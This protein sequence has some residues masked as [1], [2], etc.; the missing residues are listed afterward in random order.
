LPAREKTCW[1]FERG[2]RG[3]RRRLLLSLPPKIYADYVARSAH[4]PL[5]YSRVAK[6]TFSPGSCLGIRF[7]LLDLFDRY[8]TFFRQV[9][10]DR[11]SSLF[12]SKVHNMW[13]AVSTSNHFQNHFQVTS[14][15]VTMRGDQSRLLIGA[16][17]K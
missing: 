17:G 14:A 4:P 2:T 10:I 12:D 9:P 13:E 1:I 8:D 7:P 5:T 11:T 6:E 3:A 15:A 16:H